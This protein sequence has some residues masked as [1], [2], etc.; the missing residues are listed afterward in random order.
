MLSKGI[1]LLVHVARMVAERAERE[2]ALS[3]EVLR[4]FPPLHREKGI[5]S[6]FAH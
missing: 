2:V 6:M 4:E 1:T 5:E 3:V